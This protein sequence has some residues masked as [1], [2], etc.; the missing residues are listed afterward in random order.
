MSKISTRV[1]KIMLDEIKAA[2]SNNSLPQIAK[3]ADIPYQSL[4]VIDNLNTET[5][6]LETANSIACAYGYFL[7]RI[8]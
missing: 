5:T 2:G 8:G 3:V 1:V 7:V 6:A 4:D